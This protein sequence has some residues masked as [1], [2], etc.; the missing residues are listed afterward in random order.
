MIVGQLY[1]RTD[2]RR[3]GAYTIFYMGI[4]LGA[5][6]GT[7]LV[8]YLGQTD[9]LGATASALAGIGMLA[10][11]VVFV[12]G[13]ALLRARARRRSRWRADGM[14]LYASASRGRGDLGAG[15]VS[16]R[17]PEPADVSASLLGYVLRRPRCSSLRFDRRGAGRQPG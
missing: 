12:L 16:G 10:R 3:D 1:P 5:A 8:G 13:K 2:I 15:P 17:H 14:M 7:I 11:P 9:R 6:L 4:N